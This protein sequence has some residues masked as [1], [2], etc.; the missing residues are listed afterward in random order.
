MYSVKK[1]H[2]GN[3]DCTIYTTQSCCVLQYTPVSTIYGSTVYLPDVQSDLPKEWSTHNL[4]L[5]CLK[6]WNSHTMWSEIKPKSQTN[7]QSR[8]RKKIGK[9]TCLALCLLL[10][11]IKHSAHENSVGL[12]KSSNECNIILVSKSHSWRPHLT[13]F[14][15]CISLICM[16]WGWQFWVVYN[17]WHFQEVDKPKYS[18]YMHGLALCNG[19]SHREN[20]TGDSK[21]CVAHI[22]LS[23]VIHVI[24]FVVAM[25]L[26]QV[27]AHFWWTFLVVL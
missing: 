1:N 21:W 16:S 20:G 7:N 27:A 10:C 6:S 13:Y 26:E 19:H 22:I 8:S 15:G 9:R 12:K 2:G 11:L 24:I 4:T 23:F 25:K 14:C 17:A 5:T 18:M 3:W